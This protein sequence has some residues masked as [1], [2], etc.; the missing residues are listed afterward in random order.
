MEPQ[1][2]LLEHL[3]LSHQHPAT[4]F[5]YR[6][7]RLLWALNVSV[8]CLAGS[9]Q[10]AQTEACPI[11]EPVSELWVPAVDEELYLHVVEQVQLEALIPVEVEPAA[12]DH[13]AGFVHMVHLHHAVEIPEP[14]IA[15]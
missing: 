12:S 2:D 6:V 1:R 15:T 13:C 14:L 4:H 11:T 7:T 5:Q 10:V 3:Q 9:E 8:C